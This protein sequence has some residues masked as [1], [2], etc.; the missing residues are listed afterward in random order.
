MSVALHVGDLLV[1]TP[2]PAW[3]RDV[4][5]CRLI[6]SMGWTTQVPQN[7]LLLVAAPAGP[8][9]FTVRVLHNDQLLD[10]LRADVK[11]AQVAR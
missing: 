1:A 4:I 8:I 5:N 10:V 2:R 6:G 7:T 11:P 3:G 9:D